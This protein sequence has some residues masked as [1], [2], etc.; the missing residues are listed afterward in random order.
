MRKT[1][2]S[3]P[4]LLAFGILTCL[5]ATAGAQTIFTE[6]FDGITGLGLNGGP[7]GQVTTT[8]DLGFGGNLAGWSK[9]GAG[10]IHAVDT[11][12]TWPGPTTSPQN[13]GVMIWQNNVIT[14]SAGISESNDIG[15][16]YRISFLAAGAV[17][18]APGQ[19][20][21]GSTDSLQI[22]L[23]RASDSA[24][25]HTFNHTPAA[26]VGAGELGLL[27]VDFSYTGDGSGDIL[28]RIG[29]GNANQGRFQGTIDDL[30][31]SIADP[32]ALGI[33]FFTATP[34]VLGD[35]GEL[36]T[37]DWLVS[38]L[39]LDSLVITPGDIDVLANTDGAGE[40]SFPLNPGP[41]G[42]A[43]YTL[44]AGKDD[45]RVERKVTVT[46]PAPEIVAFE[47]SPTGAGPGDA[48]MF[49][50][51]VGLPVTTLMLTPGDIDLLPHTDVEGIGVFTLASGPD[52]NT[53]YTLTA[54]RGTSLSTASATRT[55]IDPNAIFFDDFGSF[56]V[57]DP[58][59]FNGGQFESGLVVAF[60]GDLVGWD[61]AGGG[62]VHMVDQ[63]NVFGVD[64]NPPDFSVMIWQDNVIALAN[65]IAGSN[66]S[67][68]AYAVSYAAGP[69]VYQQGGQQTGETDGILIEVLRADDSVLATHTQ[70]P[71]V[72]AGAPT[73]VADS[74]DYVG[75]GSGDIRLRI[76]PAAPGSGRFGGTIDKVSVAQVDLAPVEITEVMR[77]AQT[78]AVTITFD[79]VGGVIYE[80]WGS[81][82]LQS[83][84]DLDDNVVGTGNSTQFTDDE[85]APANPHYYYQVRSP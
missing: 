82:D 13:W 6:D 21:D 5:G 56:N 32:G 70:L 83:W 85:F 15:T 18:E 84:H 57:P 25:L 76:G 71:G 44:T 77:D 16:Q 64:N 7:A 75:D 40:G 4:G 24:V 17:Y 3:H 81:A 53:T 19:V 31:L 23:L 73:L 62:V 12:N 78:L 52:E 48:A 74:F 34:S 45:L 46:L 11:A 42:T 29:P 51:E 79:S 54:T 35:A 43:E 36:V 27:P 1:S 26:P 10:T 63:A 49:S 67:G 28:F 65:A 30:E 61:K 8:H 80:V 37:F 47:I 20:N 68:V 59:N 58:G 9:S 66:A 39:P 14:Q 55:L 72:W 50:W 41:D 22:E 69:A 2:R 33:A 38:G 60:G